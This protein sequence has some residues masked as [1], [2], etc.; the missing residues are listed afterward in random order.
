M[1]ALAR[2][3]DDAQAPGDRELAQD[4]AHSP[5]RCR[6]DDRVALGESLRLE[7]V[8]RR[9]AGE[10]ETARDL[11]VH[12]VGHRGDR[13]GRCQHQVARR[14]ARNRAEDT[15]PHGDVAHV[16]PDRLHDSGELA[17]DGR[18]Q[19]HCEARRAPPDLVV[20]GIEAGGREPDAHLALLGS[21]NGDRLDVDHLRTA[22]RVVTSGAGGHGR[23]RRRVGGR[24]VSART[25]AL[26]SRH[27]PL[28]DIGTFAPTPAAPTGLR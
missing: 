21:G 14:P 20:D 27:A 11:E 8:P 10:R 23:G 7:R 24:C 15:I 4:A 9:L 5:R 26:H 2:R 25:H 13:L 6:D 1:I 3:T 16:A 22:D 18:R 12:V 17:T 28:G 19:R